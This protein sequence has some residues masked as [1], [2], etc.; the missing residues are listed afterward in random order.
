M[1]TNK[2]NKDD[3]MGIIVKLYEF[4]NIQTSKDMNMYNIK[5]KSYNYF[6]LSF[7]DMCK[8]KIHTS[9]LRCEIIFKSD[10]CR[11]F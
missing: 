4:I 5:L 9:V 7:T 8:S 2:Y 10:T 1:V 3:I 6:V 11:G